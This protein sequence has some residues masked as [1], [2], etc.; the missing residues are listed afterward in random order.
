M[1]EAGRRRRLRR[2]SN[3]AT[4]ACEQWLTH[5]ATR[6]IIDRARTD[7]D[8][9][10]RSIAEVAGEKASVH[11]IAECVAFVTPIDAGHARV[12]TAAEWEARLSP[13]QLSLA[14][15]VVQEVRWKAQSVL[16]TLAAAGVP[17]EPRL[18]ADL[19]SVAVLLVVYRIDWSVP[20]EEMARSLSFYLGF[21]Y[22]EDGRGL[23]VSDRMGVRDRR[24]ADELRQDFRQSRA[25]YRGD[26]SRGKA[27]RPPGTRTVGETA[28]L[29]EVMPQVLA[30]FPD[31]T[32]AALVREWT[33]NDNSA[34]RRL[35]DLMGKSATDVPPAAR[36]LRRVIAEL[37]GQ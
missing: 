35:R 17:V 3:D 28:R 10:R 2:A 34:G 5:P 6:Q 20:S 7:F 14:I 4:R 33:G 31:A 25:D 18:A 15:E 32:A 12:G 23:L 26:L 16:R 11:A 13:D 30:E 8:P 22:H 27:G 24:A 19:F 29:R 21:G 1:D 37:R 36:T 9:L